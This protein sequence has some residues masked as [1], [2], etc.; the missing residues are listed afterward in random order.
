MNDYRL[1]KDQ[2]VLIQG[3]GR[4]PGPRMACAFAAQGATV[5]V[6]DLS[7]VLLN[8]IET[9]ASTLPGAIHSFV[10]DTSRGMPARA[11]LD[12]VAS[13]CGSIN[14]LITNPRIAPDTSLIEMDEWDWQRTIEANLN[15]VFLLMHLVARQMTNEKGGVI[16]NLISDLA[17]QTPEPGKAAYAASQMGLIALTRAAAQEF[18]AYNIRVYGIY[19]PGHKSNSSQAKHW[20]WAGELNPQEPLVQ[21]YFSI[22]DW[23][24]FL[25]SQESEP[26]A[27][28]I[29]RA[30]DGQPGLRSD[31]GFIP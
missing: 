21:Q 10:G 16:I 31:H 22:E 14:I 3:A 2:S 13:T 4:Q 15:G 29:F 11:L 1:L 23:V 28:Q 6:C 24:L 18:I 30:V 25:C 17:N 7:P 5:A 12:E 8:P 26:I 9:S 20:Q 19:L 27:G